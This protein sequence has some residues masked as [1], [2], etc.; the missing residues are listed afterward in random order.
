MNTFARRTALGL[1]TAVATTS[2][3]GVALSS[4]AAAA[5]GT[6]SLAAVLDADGNK[7]DKNSRDFDIV[8]RAV[9][10]V[11]KNKPESPVAVLADGDVRLTAF[12][13]TDRAF[14]RLVKDL[15]GT[16]PDSEKA[17][18]G[19]VKSFG[20]DTVETVLLYHVVPGTTIKS[21][22]AA[23]ADG[24]EL[25]TAQ[26]GTLV[27]DVT[28]NGIFLADADTDDRDPKLIAALL[29]VN[30]GNKQIAHGIN[31][32]LRPIDL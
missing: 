16:A 12:V 19:A 25:T 10:V 23:D 8:D 6:Q 29:D 21:G 31:R 15:T 13:P 17:A 30:R 26:G 20:V 5:P 14:F 11:L 7:L 32:V 1:A 3:A 28:E 18:F 22:Q 4:P 24:A 27:V 9:R 2:V